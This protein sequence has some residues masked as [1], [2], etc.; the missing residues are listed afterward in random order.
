MSKL[1]AETDKTKEGQVKFI[2]KVAP[3]K[4]QLHSQKDKTKENDGV[5]KLGKGCI[6]VSGD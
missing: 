1:A 4:E 6:P 2:K 5:K 3:N